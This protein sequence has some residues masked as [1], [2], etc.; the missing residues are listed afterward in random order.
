MF[1]GTGGID[2]G[3]VMQADISILLNEEDQDHLGTITTILQK[4]RRVDCLVAFAKWSGFAS[5]QKTLEERLKKGMTARFVIGLD[6]YQSEPRVLGRLLALKEKFGID[7][8]VSNSGSGSTFHPKIYRFDQGDK[9]V[10]II[11]SANLTGGGFSN[12]YEASVVLSTK[13]ET[14]MPAYIDALIEEESVVELTPAGLADYR[15]R[16]DTQQTQRKLADM[17]AKRAR[18][19]SGANLDVLRE[20]LQAMKDNDEEEGFAN[21]MAARRR[22]R[23]RAQAILKKIETALALSREEL[24]PLYAEVAGQCWHSSGTRRRSK[25]ITAKPELFQ[26]IVQAAARHEGSL[27]GDV[28]EHM[29]HLAKRVSGIGPNIMTEILHTY[30]NKRFPVMNQNSVEGMNL[31]GYTGFP[32]HPNKEFVTGEIYAEFCQRAE[33]IRSELGLADLSEVDAVFNYSYWLN[34]E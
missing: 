3:G 25:G 10:L 14:R 30:D 32:L 22:G 31:A 28:F 21:Q 7:V 29:R 15:A 23:A 2:R 8:L 9:I 26:E 13:T 12:N 19:A 17:R 18:P 27:A 11:G 24:M 5:I 1:T 6:L 16:Y 4:S 33:S 20:I 34:A